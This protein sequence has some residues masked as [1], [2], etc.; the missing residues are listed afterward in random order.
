[1]RNLEAVELAVP[2]ALPDAEV[3]P[4]AGDQ[5]ERR[6]L[7]GQQDRVVPKAA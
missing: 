5:V 2:V 3:E 1:L 6:R 7:L 4:S